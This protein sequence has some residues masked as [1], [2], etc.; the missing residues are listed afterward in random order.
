MSN[1]ERGIKCCTE[2]QWRSGLQY[3]HEA[4]ADTAGDLKASAVVDSWIALCYWGENRYRANV[5]DALLRGHR[6]DPENVAILAAIASFKSEE[7]ESWESVSEWC[8]KLIVA[9]NESSRAWSVTSSLAWNAKE[10][11]EAERAAEVA[12]GRDPLDPSGFELKA[13]CL[14]AA[15]KLEEAENELLYL[16]LTIPRWKEVADQTQFGAPVIHY[17]WGPGGLARQRERFAG[18]PEPA[19]RIWGSLDDYKQL[20]E[21]TKIF[22]R[23]ELQAMYG[24]FSFVRRDDD[25]LTRPLVAARRR[26]AWITL[27]LNA[28]LQIREQRA[29]QGI[30]C[31]VA[32]EEPGQGLA[33]CFL[34]EA[35]SG[36]NRW[37]AVTPTS[38]VVFFY[39]LNHLLDN[40][41]P[42]QSGYERH[43]ERYSSYARLHRGGDD[44]AIMTPLDADD[45]LPYTPE[46]RAYVLGRILTPR[47]DYIPLV[48]RKVSPAERSFSVDKIY[49][50]VK[51]HP[52]LRNARS[53]LLPEIATEFIALHESHHAL[54]QHERVRQEFVLS[55]LTEQA[56]TWCAELSSDEYALRSLIARYGGHD[57][58][59]PM[60]GAIAWAALETMLVVALQ[61]RIDAGHSDYPPV[62][63]RIRR[64]REA[65][66][67][68][69]TDRTEIWDVAAIE[70]MDRLSFIG[71]WINWPDLKAAAEADLFFD[72]EWQE[73]DAYFAAH[74]DRFAEL[75]KRCGGVEHKWEESTTP[76]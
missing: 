47:N 44:G 71:H 65:F 16:L 18:V 12:I 41:Y 60:L 46:Y 20:A 57:A 42:L 5:I 13:L 17:T 32:D 23:A 52:H 45:E 2:G 25:D 64:L 54:G 38:L 1:L 69:N 55:Q 29:L 21:S 10:Y 73:H 67:N 51:V 50:M 39:S 33:G 26:L 19:S 31:I 43:M 58:S 14:L 8:Q 59:K 9:D 24:F 34:V 27:E 68:D 36:S 11:V 48:S 28:A 49:G 62:D 70:I 3:L 61:Q 15:S 63:Y 30:Y 56:W 22:Q 53:S 75:C 76:A 66:S 40:S 37:I 7:K 72:E 74:R 4:L 35:S 6:K